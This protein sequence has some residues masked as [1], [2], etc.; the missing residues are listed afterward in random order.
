MQ[1]IAQFKYA[2]TDINE[3]DFSCG[4][5]FAQSLVHF[6]KCYSVFSLCPF[7]VRYER[8]RNERDI[9]SS[10]DNNNNKQFESNISVN[11]R[12]FQFQTNG[13]LHFTY[14]NN[15]DW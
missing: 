9:L 12:S 5:Q 15:S 3:C 4:A 1:T 13:N 2:D 11:G 10:D 6:A 8:F 7:C 14:E